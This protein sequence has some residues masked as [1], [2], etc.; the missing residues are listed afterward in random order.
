MRMVHGNLLASLL[1]CRTGGHETLFEFSASDYFTE[2]ERADMAREAYRRLRSTL[3]PSQASAADEE[4]DDIVLATDSDVEPDPRD[5]PSYT[6]CVRVSDKGKSK[7][8]AA[9]VPRTLVVVP[10]TPLSPDVFS[11]VSH[12]PHRR[13]C[14]VC[15]EPMDVEGDTPLSLSLC[16]N[17]AH[18]CCPTCAITVVANAV[19]AAFRHNQAGAEAVA[20][21]LTRQFNGQVCGRDPWD[22]YD[23]EHDALVVR[24]PE[25]RGMFDPSD[26]LTYWWTCTQA[27]FHPAHPVDWD[28]IPTPP[29]FGPLDAMAYA[30]P[31]P[32][33]PEDD[34]DLWDDPEWVA[35]TPGGSIGALSDDDDWSEN[36]G[37]WV[38]DSPE[39]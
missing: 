23:E 21:E 24:C 20:S 3:P 11:H 32:S 39:Y 9:A 17:V 26:A 8:T 34:M 14:P 12:Q 35:P 18:Q 19:V 2:R 28:H 31:T 29:A 6:V 27:G 37:D 36:T 16:G 25:C 1:G 10:D 15:C 33:P 4:D 13:T 38:V 5:A 22:G 7:N 30:T